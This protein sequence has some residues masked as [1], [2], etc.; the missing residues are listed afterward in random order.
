MKVFITGATSG[1]GRQLALDY[2]ASGH[3]VIAAGRSATAL[4]TL[5]NQGMH[6]LELDLLDREATL[7]ELTDQNDFD[8]PFLMDVQAASQAIRKGI[9]KKQAEIH[10]PKKLTWGMKAAARLPRS[11]WAAL[12]RR[13][14]TS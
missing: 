10:F 2:H 14:V 11:L 12:A 3:A 9:E 7:R 5:A 1:I 8:M 6:T 4:K 13:M